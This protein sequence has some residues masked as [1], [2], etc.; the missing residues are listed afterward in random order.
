M[1]DLVWILFM[2]A[3]KCKI[4]KPLDRLVVNF[5]F[6]LGGERICDAGSDLHEI[7]HFVNR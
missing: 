4:R 1:A 6:S 3:V 5:Q 2:N 7:I